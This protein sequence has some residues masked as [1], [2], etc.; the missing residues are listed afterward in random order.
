MFRKYSDNKRTK[1][2]SVHRSLLVVG[3]V[4]NL[5]LEL[6]ACLSFLSAGLSAGSESMGSYSLTV[7]EVTS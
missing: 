6:E 3:T 7:N 4:G 5:N 1:S 2:L